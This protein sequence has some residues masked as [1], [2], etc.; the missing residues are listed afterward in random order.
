MTNNSEHEKE[1]DVGVMTL[2]CQT[3]ISLVASYYFIGYL[4]GTVDLSTS[5]TGSYKSPFISRSF[6]SE[7]IS[8]AMPYILGFF[9]FASVSI[10]IQLLTIFLKQAH[11]IFYGFILIYGILSFPHIIKAYEKTHI[12]PNSRLQETPKQQAA[13]KQI[14]KFIL[15]DKLFREKFTIELIPEEGKSGA[16]TVEADETYKAEKLDEGFYK[17]TKYFKLDNPNY[18]GNQYATD[19]LKEYFLDE[20]GKTMEMFVYT[21]AASLIDREDSSLLKC[22]PVNT[23]E[24]RHGNT[25][26]KVQKLASSDEC[27]CQSYQDNDN[28]G[29]ITGIQCAVTSKSSCRYKEKTVTVSTAKTTDGVLQMT[30]EVMSQ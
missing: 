20:L 7:E 9:A 5:G 16:M 30:K 21:E 14:E 23:N 19:L 15:G 29:K 13:N 27:E 6:S 1:S 18:S 11:K 2:I 12:A 22:Y 8:K 3:I 28:Y 24:C 4:C 10:T 25:V 26:I 17:I